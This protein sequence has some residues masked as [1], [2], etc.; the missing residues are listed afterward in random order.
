MPLW[1][2]IIMI[3]LIAAVVMAAIAVYL[4]RTRKT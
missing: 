1:A 4:T 3:V 2:W